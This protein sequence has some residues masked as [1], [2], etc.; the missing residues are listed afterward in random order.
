MNLNFILWNR[1]KA[2]Q[3]DPMIHPVFSLKRFYFI[4]IGDGTD[5]ADF[6]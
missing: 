2:S 1:L 3:I 5:D 6:P 4:P